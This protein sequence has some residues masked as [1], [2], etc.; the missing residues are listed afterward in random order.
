MD[1]TKHNNFTSA[2]LLVLEARSGWKDRCQPSWQLEPGVHSKHTFS[3]IGGLSALHS[4]PAGSQ[5]FLWHLL[6]WSPV[7]I[8]F[9][10]NSSVWSS[11]P[12]CKQASAAG[13]QPFCWPPPAQLSEWFEHRTLYRDVERPATK[14]NSWRRSCIVFVILLTNRWMTPPKSNPFW[15]CLETF[16]C[17]LRWNLIRQQ[18]YFETAFL[19]HTTPPD[20]ILADSPDALHW[21][22][23]ITRT[24]LGACFAYKT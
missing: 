24:M 1:S 4:H 13:L 6:L 10:L 21:L 8:N 3:A 20:W 19:D 18:I 16:S 5:V 17:R 7:R 11:S 22:G 12:E 23:E 15:L 2:G 14:Q 9:L